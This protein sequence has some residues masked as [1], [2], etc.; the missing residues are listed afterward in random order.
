MNQLKNYLSIFSILIAL[1]LLTITSCT[2]DGNEDGL[3]N[4]G[5]V[6][7]GP[8]QKHNGHEY[9]ELGLSVKWATYNVGATAPEEYG[10]YFAWGETTAKTTYNW[11]T[12]KYSEG[13]E[14][15]LTKYCS[16]PQYGIVDK[17]SSLELTDDVARVNWEG[18]W[19][20]PTLSEWD[21]LRSNCIW[22]W[23]THN[24]VKGYEVISRKNGNIIFL[25][26]TGVRND[27]DF[28]D[29]GSNGNYW[30]SLLLPGSGYYAYGLSF[31]SS[32]VD[33]F[34]NYRSYGRSVRAVCE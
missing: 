24:G 10:D 34:T 13:S 33:F 11:S 4:N 18:R 32:S 26:A 14:I 8:T 3:I 22:R 23:T 31:C 21:E 27:D 17:K 19:R 12:Y 15:T 5:G 6:S 30:S 25:P 1:L 29:T 7:L 16:D 9:V 2:G 20:M 28:R